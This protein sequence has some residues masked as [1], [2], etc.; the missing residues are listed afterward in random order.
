MTRKNKSAWL[1]LLLVSALPLSAEATSAK[2]KKKL[3]LQ[4]LLNQASGTSQQSPSVAGVRGLEETSAEIDTKARD[5]AAIEG[6]ER[7]VVHADELRKFIDEGKL[8]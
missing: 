8:R 3:T 1:F 7:V 5:F 2:K 6:L 4:D